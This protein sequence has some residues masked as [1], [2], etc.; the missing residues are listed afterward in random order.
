GT[1]R[2]IADH[3][4]YSVRANKVCGDEVG[5]LTDAFN[6]MLAQIQS[7]DSALRKAEEKYRLIFEDAIEGMFQTTPD[8]KYLSVNPALARMYGYESPEELMATVSDI[9]P[10]VYVN[11]E[12]R[13]EFK[14]LIE[15]QGFVERFEYEVYRKDRSKI[16]LSE[17]AR[18]VRDANG[19]V[20]FYEGAMQDMTERKRV[21]EV[22]RASKA[23]SEFLSRMSHELRTPLNAILG[24]GQLLERQKPTEVQ[25]TRISYILSAGRHLLELINEVLDIAR[26]EAGR[27]QFSLEPVSVTDAVD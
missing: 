20:I 7:Q 4:D 12:R 8:G 9:G 27:M 14:R 22:E 24:F 17:N 1:A 5:V 13:T 25:R 2:T 15:A 11:P 16:W 18:A 3:N 10:V 19:V 21:D 23:K 6:Q 26:I